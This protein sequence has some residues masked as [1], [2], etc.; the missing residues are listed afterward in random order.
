MDPQTQLY[1]RYYSA[2]SGGSSAPFAGARRAQHGAGLWDILIGILRTIL[3]IAAHGASTFL[4]QTLKAKESGSAQSWGDAARAALGSTAENVITNSLQMLQTAGSQKTG[5]GGRRRHRRQ[6]RKSRNN[7]EG[8]GP[9]VYKRK[10][11]SR[12]KGSQRHEKKIKFLN[13]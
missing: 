12:D 13:F 5:S 1:L 11:E 3:P 8:G 7:D 9:K 10:R 6:R 2:Q 4:N